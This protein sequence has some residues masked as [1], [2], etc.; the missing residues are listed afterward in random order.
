MQEIQLWLKNNKHGHWIVIDDLP[1]SFDEDRFVKTSEL[2]G[3]TESKAV[4]AIAK[5]KIII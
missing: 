5:L 2:E 4:E 3:L 1:L